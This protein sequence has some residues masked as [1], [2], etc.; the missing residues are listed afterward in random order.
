MDQTALVDLKPPRF[1]EGRTFW[2]AG[3]SKQYECDNCEGIPQQWQQFCPYMEQIKGRIGEECY[4][5]GHGADGAGHFDYMC[6]V[7]V[8]KDAELPPELK[9]LEIKK[10]KYAVFTHTD[11]ISTI[12][13]TWNTILTKWLAE[14]GFEYS[15]AP[16]FE[17]IGENFNGETGLGGVEI[18]IPI[19]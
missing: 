15:M 6:A 18:W 7:E 5:V 8:S 3:L 19:E 17:L 13:R 4:G 2:V 11:H 16:N 9:L 10:H 12:G 14:S 1:E